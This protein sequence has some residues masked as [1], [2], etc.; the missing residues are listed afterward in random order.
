MASS[1]ATRTG[2]ASGAQPAITA[3]TATFSTVASAQSGGIL[4]TTWSGSAA[5][6]PSIARTRASVGGTIGS[7]SV[8]PCPR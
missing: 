2:I 8:Q 4:P 6:P 3:L 7:P 1:A 5:M